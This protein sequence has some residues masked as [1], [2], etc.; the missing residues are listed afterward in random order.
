MGEQQRPG[1]VDEPLNDVTQIGG[2]VWISV[3]HELADTAIDSVPRAE[4]A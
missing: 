4:I 1:T 2:T 3:H